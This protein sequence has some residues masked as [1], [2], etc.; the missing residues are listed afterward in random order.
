MGD[1]LDAASLRSFVERGAAV[2]N[3]A[4]LAGRAGAD[5]R[6]AL[7]NLARACGAAGASRV[8]HVSTAVVVGRSPVQVV[9]EQTSCAPASP[10]EAAKLEGE[11]ILLGFLK[12]ICPVTI[13]RPTEVFGEGGRGL[14]KLAEGVMRDSPLAA[15]LKLALVGRRKLN[16]VYVQNVAAAIR[17]LTTTDAPIDGQRYIV[18]DD[19]APQ[20]NYSDVVRLLRLSWQRPPSP[21][22]VVTC[23]PALLG[24]LL[25]ARGRSNINP[26]RTYSAERLAALGFRERIPFVT[27]L[28]R[29]A[30]WYAARPSGSAA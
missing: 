12:G 25:W 3:L 21:S 19:D 15:A 23:P 9:T 17:F 8:V 4:F 18:S 1:L 24:A 2:V 13:L 22:P 16:L 10:Y 5:N 29:F 14:V 11:E 26:R 6:A 28:E 20:N 30:R 27:G 7:E